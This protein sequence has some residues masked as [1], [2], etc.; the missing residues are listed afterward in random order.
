[1]KTKEAKKD[2]LIVDVR[3][4]D[5]RGGNIRGA[6]NSPS[7]QF[8]ANV[9][10]LVQDTKDTPIVV[11]HCMLS[12]QR[13]PKAARVRRIALLRCNLNALVMRLQIYAETRDALQAEGKDKD[14]EVY[15]LRGGFGEF[16][17]KFKVRTRG[18][19]RVS[20]LTEAVYPG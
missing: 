18:R 10:K 19:L 17:A 5:F 9:D 14:H 6:L 13:G 8:L 11:F 2:Y 20:A 3:D 7:T 4:D 1:V 16:Q 12:Q 15:V